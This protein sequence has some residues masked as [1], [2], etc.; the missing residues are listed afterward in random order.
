MSWMDPEMVLPEEGRVVV[1]D[2]LEYW[3]LL[4]GYRTGECWFDLRDNPI[5]VT[6]WKEVHA[7][8]DPDPDPGGE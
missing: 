1:C 7:N 8:D 2:V 5:Q 4:K 6:R 3:G